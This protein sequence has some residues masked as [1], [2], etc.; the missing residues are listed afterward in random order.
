[1]C[2]G[3]VQNG[4]LPFPTGHR[5]IPGAA[6]N[7]LKKNKIKLKKADVMSSRTAAMQ[8]LQEDNSISDFPTNNQL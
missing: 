1:L 2:G 7:C 5:V 8:N 4:S 3:A 6:T